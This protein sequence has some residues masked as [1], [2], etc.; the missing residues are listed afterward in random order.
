M[1]QLLCIHFSASQHLQWNARKPT[2][3]KQAIQTALVV[4]AVGCLKAPARMKQRV[5][6]KN[7]NY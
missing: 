6:V 1:L 3:S 5:T 7:L 4:Q 2:D